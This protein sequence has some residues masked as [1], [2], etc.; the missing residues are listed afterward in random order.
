[1][2]LPRLQPLEGPRLWGTY[3][4][5]NAGDDGN[6]SARHGAEMG[7]DGEETG[8]RGHEPLN[9]DK[10]GVN[11]AGDCLISGDLVIE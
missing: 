5:A 8:D 7:D 6:G 3:A 9:E 2:T 11:M 1:M 10:E 4:W